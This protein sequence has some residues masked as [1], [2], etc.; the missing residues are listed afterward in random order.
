MRPRAR[1]SPGYGAYW[2]GPA[3]P[4][5]TLLRIGVLGGGLSPAVEQVVAAVVAQGTA[6]TVYPGDAGR[7][8]AI[9][10]ALEQCDAQDILVLLDDDT[11]PQ[12]RW[13]AS[14]RA[15]WSRAGVDVGFVAGPIL[16]GGAGVPWTTPLQDLGVASSSAIESGD[17]TFHA[18]NLSIRATA[19]RGVGAAWPARSPA[20]LRDWFAPE[21]EIQRELLRSGWRGLWVQRAAVHRVADPSVIGFARLIE[22]R[23]RM[24]A[25]TTILGNREPVLA[26]L[27]AG[28]KHLAGTGVALAR[29]RRTLAGARAARAAEQF[30]HTLGGVLAR[31]DFEPTSSH[32]S[33]RAH[34]PCNAPA[35][36]RISARQR[37]VDRPRALILLYHRVT[38]RKTDPL[39]LCVSPERFR[40]Q[41]DVLRSGWPVVTLDELAEA[42]Q[43]G[44]GLPRRAVAITFDDGY[45]DNLATAAP[46]LTERNLPATLFVSTGHVERKRGFWWDRLERLLQESPAGAPPP[47]RVTVSEHVLAWPPK[48]TEERSEVAK[49][50][51]AW[52]RPLHPNEIDEVLATVRAWADVGADVNADADRPLT[53]EE[54]RAAA[55]TFT[56]GAHTRNHVSLG[57]Q[58]RDVQAREILASRQD[59]TDWLG[60]TP[61]GFSYPFG[62]AGQD[63]DA[64][65]RRLVQDAG[66]A[67]ATANVAGLV[68]S[69]S[70]PYSLPRLMAP[71]LDG[72][73]FAA[74]LETAMTGR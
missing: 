52:L 18:G 63:F 25:R 34:V 32:T 4:M 57:T 2:V 67:Y 60:A 47:L 45:V 9:N 20:H 12:P 27:T 62:V 49:H 50:L 30:G 28:T 23:M 24:G 13:L 58:P 54:L 29:G 73:A 42:V 26:A 53:I 21:H 41:L 10:A 69:S 5:A 33:F 71:D 7:A 11:I 36:A 16:D 55:A 31:R 59:L 64:T 51:H 14:I 46:A 3:R 72:L 48:T 19:L 15:A 74:W 22:Q 6:P 43:R 66:F 61:T 44:H 56:V 37:R 38:V 35:Q 39:R 70:D 17:R 8:A 65:A 40:E 68:T 1:C